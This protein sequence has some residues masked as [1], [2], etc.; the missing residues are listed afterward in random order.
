MVSLL[1]LYRLHLLLLC[2]I[3]FDCLCVA[4]KVFRGLFDSIFIFIDSVDDLSIVVRNSDHL[5]G[6][7]ARHIEILDQKDQLEPVLV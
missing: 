7:V 2:G 1:C 5:R 4:F 6:L 3:C